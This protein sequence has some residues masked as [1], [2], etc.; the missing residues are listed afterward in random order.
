MAHIIIP[1]YQFLTMQSIVLRLKRSRS[2]LVRQTFLQRTVS[3]QPTLPLIIG[4][5]NFIT[6]QQGITKCSQRDHRIRG[7][8][9]EAI[10]KVVK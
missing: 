3:L 1:K 7:I 9:R 2:S 6:G 8:R 4:E 10:S 5:G